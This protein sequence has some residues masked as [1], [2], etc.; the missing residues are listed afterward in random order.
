MTS[1]K[2]SLQD[3]TKL[4]DEYYGKEMIRVIRSLLKHKMLDIESLSK[5]TGYSINTVRRALYTLQNLGFVYMHRKE[6]KSYWILKTNDYEKIIE[7]LLN[8]IP[9]REPK[10]QK[11]GAIYYCPQCGREFTLDEAMELSFICP[12]DGTFLVGK[13]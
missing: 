10:R 7:A 11:E 5:K 12:E 1:S 6:D 9:K 13:E 8:N 4:I 3:A 2:L